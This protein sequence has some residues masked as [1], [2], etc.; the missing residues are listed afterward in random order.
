MNEKNILDKLLEEQNGYIR[1]VDVQNE[2][3]SKYAALDYVRK[4]EM[5]KAAPGI[6]ILPNTWED[7]LYLIQL[8]NR[9]IVFSHET[10]LYIHNLSDREPFLPRQWCCSTYCET[11]MVRAWIDA[12]ADLCW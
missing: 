1:L 5:E 2:G 11:G 6:Y 7:R 12:G 9:K 10:A 3:V 4:N 8:R